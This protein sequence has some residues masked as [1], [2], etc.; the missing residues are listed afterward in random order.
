METRDD[1]VG[2]PGVLDLHPVGAQLDEMRLSGTGLSCRSASKNCCDFVL[3]QSTTDCPEI[4]DVLPIGTVVVTA[5]PLSPPLRA[6]ATPT[7]L[8]RW[9][10][11]ATVSASTLS[12]ASGN[13]RN[14]LA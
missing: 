7:R 5:P 1:G 6:N 4:V 11:S 2:V 10:P 8:C 9:S 12:V 13:S 14:G 3:S